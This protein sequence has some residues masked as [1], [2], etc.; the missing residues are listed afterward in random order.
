MLLS[1]TRTMQSAVRARVQ[2]LFFSR[3]VFCACFIAFFTT[4]LAPAQYG[5]VDPFEASVRTL[6]EGIAA[7]SDGEQHAAMVALR[8]LCDP[9]LKP[10]LE[11]LLKSDD[12]SLRVDSVLGLA[13]LDPSKKVDITLVLDLPGEG[14]RETSINA[15][16]ALELLDTTRVE[17]ILAWDDVPATQRLLLACEL[18]RLG[19]I[20]ASAMVRKL[21]ESKTP[22][23]AGL[24]TALLLDL[25][26]PQA[27]AIKTRVLAEI[28]ALP[29][30]SRS[31]VV[32]QIAAASSMSRLTAAAP[33]IATLLSIPEMT[34][35]ARMRSLGSLLVLSPETAYPVFAAAVDADR[36]QTSLMRHAAVLLASGVRAPKS[37]WDR[38][39]NG[40]A[41]IEAFADAGTEIGESKDEAAYARLVNLKHRVA[42]RAALE[43]ARRLGPSSDRAL[44]IACAKFLLA[45]KRAAAP[46]AETGT[47]AMSRLALVAP[48]ELRPMLES[49]VDDRVIQE[50]ILLALLSAGTREAATVAQVAHGQ[51]SRLGEAMISVLAARHADTLSSVDLD[52]LATVASGGTGA[53][54]A[55]RTQ[56]AWLWLRHAKRTT[57][58]I[59]TLLGAASVAVPTATIQSTAPLATPP[60][61]GTP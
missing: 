7:A 50:S 34:P 41:L 17:A 5:P 19:G 8:E 60:K 30:R 48:E 39:R 25:Q 47:Q 36:S 24:A 55:I 52:L 54:A 14:D 49:A 38:L 23:L 31:E 16:V 61:A 22:E 26:D 1:Y 13:E 51:S 46:L 15:I 32:A 3:A 12:W 10:L 37:E 28:T 6:K 2:H 42:L 9:A 43:G 59:D 40:D 33:F 45:E 18:R 21:S 44:G 11:R 56:A 27:E 53:S 35:D 29:A 20:P 4:T 58:A 57:S